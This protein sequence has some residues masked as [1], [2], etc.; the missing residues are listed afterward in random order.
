MSRS[1]QPARASRSAASAV[2]EAARAAAD[3]ASGASRGH[4]FDQLDLGRVGLAVGPHPNR[5]AHLRSAGSRV[6]SSASPIGSA[7]SV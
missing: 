3:S 2:S 1:G 4:P 6:S 7:R 5:R